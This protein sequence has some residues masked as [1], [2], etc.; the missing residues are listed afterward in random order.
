M[1]FYYNVNPEYSTSSETPYSVS[2]IMSMNICQSQ[3]NN[4][5]ILTMG[6]N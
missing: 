1:T 4:L 3:N 5:I 6:I 2:V